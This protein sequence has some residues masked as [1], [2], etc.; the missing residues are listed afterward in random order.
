MVKIKR[1]LSRKLN[2]SKARTKKE[3]SIKE[4]YKEAFRY[5]KESD[6]YIAIIIGIFSFL[7]MLGFIFPYIAPKEALDP[8][9]SIVQDWVKDILAKT[10]GLDFFGM[11]AFIFQNNLSV[12]FI[13]LFSGFIFAI[14]PIVLLF[15]NAL[16]VGIISGLVANISGIS[17][18]WKILPHGIFEL[19]AIF[20]SIALGIRFGIDL[21]I[22]C[23][24]FYKKELPR[25]PLSIYVIICLL[26]FPITFLIILILTILNKSLR[27]KL[28]FNFIN[29]I[30]VFI[31]IIIPL[32][33]IASFIEAGLI[34]L[35]G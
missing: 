5:I 26:L 34:I 30:R 22:N 24:L 18:F 15:S 6:N 19:P 29:S 10:E 32:L 12:A 9:L 1:K 35:L 31:F 8:I 33:L 7:F 23:L 16:F 13:S 17:V 4:E 21:M 2:I 25:I 3:F 14:L 27:N 11:W 20:I 28:S